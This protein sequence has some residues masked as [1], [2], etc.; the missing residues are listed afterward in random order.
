MSN[1]PYSIFARPYQ[2]RLMMSVS[3]PDVDDVVHILNHALNDREEAE[4]RFWSAIDDLRRQVRQQL[5]NEDLEDTETM[6][7]VFDCMFDEM[8]DHHIDECFR[9]VFEPP[10]PLSLMT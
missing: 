7:K 9:K 2:R 8:G 6:V 5:K 3:S 4:L 10:V 1:H